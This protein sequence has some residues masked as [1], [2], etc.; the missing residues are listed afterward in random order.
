MITVAV[1]SKCGTIG[2]SSKM[3]CC[4]SGGSWFT[5]CGG[6]GNAQL[7]HTW[8][9]GIQAC[10]TRLRSRKVI[11]HQFNIGQQIGINSSQGADIVKYK[12]PATKT[13]TFTPVHTSA[14]MSIITPTYTPDKVSTTMS[15]R[16]FNTK[17]SANTLLTSSTLTSASTRECVHVLEIISSIFCVIVFYRYE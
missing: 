1:C 8:Q 4:G 6:F 5:K 11:D 15:A 10:K 14:P 12:T 16:T 7:R 9:E 13:F 2:K 17:V 3:S